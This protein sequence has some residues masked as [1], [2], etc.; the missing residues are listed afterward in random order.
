MT[1][2]LR[3][4]LAA[5]RYTTTRLQRAR[6]ECNATATL[7]CKRK[8]NHG[9]HCYTLN[10]VPLG[11]QNAPIATPHSIAKPNSCRHRSLGARK[12]RV[13][14][15]GST[16]NQKGMKRPLSRYVYCYTSIR[17]KSKLQLT[18]T[19]AHI[20]YRAKHVEVRT[21]HNF[22]TESHRSLAK[23]TTGHRVRRL[24]RRE[25]STEER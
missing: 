18:E 19:P 17:V 16:A 15:C 5:N 8:C 9:C 6:I 1:E 7:C 24:R 12:S 10:D 11:K 23:V 25:I 22:A 20:M 2:C 13:H 21:S 14:P 3:K 4:N